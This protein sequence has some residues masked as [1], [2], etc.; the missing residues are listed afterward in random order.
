MR[1][2]ETIVIR[3][4]RIERTPLPHG[5][6]LSGL[7]I[8]RPA[9]SDEPEVALQI[10]LVNEGRY[11]VDGLECQLIYYDDRSAFLGMDDAFSREPLLPQGRET[12]EMFVEPPSG[13]RRFELRVKATKHTFY[14]RYRS[15]VVMVA[16]VVSM[17]A[18]FALEFFKQL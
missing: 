8:R 16:M 18:L 12:L 17:I 15:E 6:T 2:P 1:R 3:E 9:W 10:E 5:L 4:D 14:S 11:P 13:A 7:V